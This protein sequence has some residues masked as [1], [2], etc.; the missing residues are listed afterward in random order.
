M[1]DRKPL[2]TFIRAFFEDHLLCRRN[3]AANTIQSYRDAIKLFLQFA[4]AATKIPVTT[5]RVTDVT[6]TLVMSFLKDLETNRANSIQTRNHRLIA[7]HRLFAYI[8][9]QEPLLLDQCRR[10]TLIPLKRGAQLPMIRYL[11]KEEVTAIIEATDRSTALGQRDQAL[12][13]FLY[14]TGARVQE[15]ADVRLEWLSLRPPA[16]VEILGKGR[17]WRTCPLWKETAKTLRRYADDQRRDCAPADTLFVNRFGAPLTR[18]G[19]E[20]IVGRYAAKAAQATTSLRNQ[21]ITPHCIRHSTAQH[22]RQSGV[23]INLIRSWLG[24]VSVDT[25][26]LYLESDL[27]MKEQALKTCEAVVAPHGRRRWQKPKADILAWLKSL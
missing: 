23:D 21:K 13:L 5:L 10:I 2:A 16:K 18:S 11:N 1:K 24:H 15:A 27:E 26:G 19:I 25:T 17:K 7:L 8:A 14:N 20:Y 9:T 22:L 3:L 4:T 12:L 6:E